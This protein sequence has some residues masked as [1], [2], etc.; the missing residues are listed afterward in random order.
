M[1]TWYA[2]ATLPAALA[3]TAG[4]WAAPTAPA[5]LYTVWAGIGPAAYWADLAM[6]WGLRSA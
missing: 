4:A 2:L 5:L 1:P 3:W 6:Y